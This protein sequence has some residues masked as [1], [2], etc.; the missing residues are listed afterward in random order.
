LAKLLIA[1]LPL[2]RVVEEA[3]QVPTIE[4][5]VLVAG[6][7]SED[8]DVWRSTTWGYASLAATPVPS[9]EFSPLYD[10][11]GLKTPTHDILPP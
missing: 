9:M 1:Y 7:P 3:I 4:I 11:A 10:V 2:S 8:E 6:W 5:A